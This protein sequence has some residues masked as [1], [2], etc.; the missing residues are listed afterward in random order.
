MDGT[1]V[2]HLSFPEALSF[3]FLG[4][5]NQEVGMGQ[6]SLWGLACPGPPLTDDW[7]PSLSPPGL[8]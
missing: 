8:G 4:L 1:T 6:G 5:E 3:S 7:P 2:H